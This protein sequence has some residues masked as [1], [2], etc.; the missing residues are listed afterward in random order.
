MV[1]LANGVLMMKE[2]QLT[3]HEPDYGFP[4]V[5]DYE[6]DTDAACPQWDA[7]I[8][9]VSCGDEAIASVLQ[10]FVGYTVSGSDSRMCEKSLL[11]YGDGSNGK[12]VFSETVMNLLGKDNY[13]S[14]PLPELA[15][16]EGMRYMFL[17]CTGFP[18]NLR[19]II[20]AP[21]VKSLNTSAFL[22]ALLLDSSV[23]FASLFINI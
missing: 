7:F 21:L 1:N 12:S 5:L 4:Y 17:N 8:Q 23:I 20:S 11:L 19:P 16:K 22:N 13:T 3:E 6:Y 9:E 18:Y 2:K 14:I 15:T 10:E